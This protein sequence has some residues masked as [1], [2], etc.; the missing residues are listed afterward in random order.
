MQ[1]S[2]NREASLNFARFFAI[3]LLSLFLVS[4]FGQEVPKGAASP[5]Q[6]PAESSLPAQPLN[7]DEIII[8]DAPEAQGPI[9]TGTSLWAIFR[10]LIALALVA[11]AVYGVVYFLRRAGRPRVES[12]TRLKVLASTHLGSNRY[13]HV[14]NL[15]EKAWLVGLQRVAWA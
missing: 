14:V 8:A 9:D 7:E 4:A 12:E 10:T 6:S 3:S 1:A 11:A 2:I 5:S 13:V 15:G